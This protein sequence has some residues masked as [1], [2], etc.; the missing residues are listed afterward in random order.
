M[1][2]E[3]RRRVAIVVGWV[4]ANCLVR[5]RRLDLYGWILQQPKRS[6]LSAFDGALL[7][8]L[9]HALRE[10]H[11]RLSL[12]SFGERAENELGV[13]KA[14]PEAIRGSL[15][16]LRAHNRI[17]LTETHVALTQ[18]AVAEDSIAKGLSFIGQRIRRIPPD[19]LNKLLESSA[20][21]LSD[22]QRYAVRQIVNVPVSILTG[23]PGTGKTS[24]VRSLLAIFEQAGYGVRLAAPT[25]RAAER[26]REVTGRPAQTLH[27][28]LHA[29]RPTPPSILRRIFPVADV[30]IVDEASMIDVFLMA[31]LIKACTAFTKLI[32]VG[33]VNQLPS[34]VAGQ[35]LFDLIESG[36]IPVIELSK[37]YRQ[38]NESRII[39][40]AEM[41][42]AGRAPDLPAPGHGK[43]DCYFIEAETAAEIARLVV[44]AA[45][46]SLP[47][48]CGADPYQSIQI[49]TPKHKGLLGATHLNERIQMALHEAPSESHT[50]AHQFLVGDR[51][52]HTKND[53]RLKVFNGQVGSVRQVTDETVAVRFGDRVVTYSRATLP[54]LTPGFAI[55]IHRSQG[56]EYPF[57]IIPI[58]ESQQ[59]MLSRELLYTALTR[60]RRM[61]VLIGSR[62]AL[63][64]AVENTVKGR[65]QT[66][67]KTALCD[68]ISSN[69]IPCVG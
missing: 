14:S 68:A 11:T 63:E 22:E 56:S 12:A 39:A 24:T 54:H 46:R 10:G 2:N 41:I 6:D 61:V 55:T 7:Q 9:N 44:N 42:K 28:M 59:P 21:E 20:A 16:R 19:R 26:L 35:V 48:R 49:L 4:I 15:D 23:A 67:L 5:I 64:L 58:H 38:A 31:R 43:S 47:Q 32:L 53:Y 69:F 8:V 65:L 60:G 45:T 1:R 25:G 40:A 51:V 29:D 62:R 36:M 18:S 66:G 17:R 33:D 52:L 34:I 37:N 13:S 57:V 30:V 27:R 50:G 3:L